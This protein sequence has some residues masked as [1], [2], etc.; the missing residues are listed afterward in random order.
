MEA[1]ES[2]CGFSTGGF[3]ELTV[4]D[5]EEWPEGETTTEF[6]T[7]YAP[8]VTQNCSGTGRAN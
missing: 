1:V 6:E 4:S 7:E 5:E 2:Q 3:E 8:Q